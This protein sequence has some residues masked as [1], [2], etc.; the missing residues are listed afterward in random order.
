MKA[1]GILALMLALL[2]GCAAAQESMQLYVHKGA[3][4]EGQVQR[5]LGLLRAEYEADDWTL[6]EDERALRELV[7]S[8]DLPDLAI[9]APGEARP[10]AREGLLVPLQE[11]ISGQHRMQRQVLDQGV[12]G[13]EMFMAPLSAMHRQMAVN[14][15]LFEDMGLGYMLDSKMYPVWYPAQFYQILEEFMIRDEVAL[16]VWRAQADTSAAIEALTQAI[17]GGMLLSE[18]GGRATADDE[19]VQVG[20]Q[21]LADAIDDGMIG[22]C[23]TREDALE[24][25][26]MGETAIFIDWTRRLQ[27]QAKEKGLEIAERPYPAAVGLPVRSFELTGVCAFSSGDA[28]RDTHLADACAMLCD[29]AQDVLG[30]RG[31]WQDGALWPASLDA[32]DLGATLRSLLCQALVGVIEE[33]RDAGEA[34]D[35]VQAAMDALRQA[36]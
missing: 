1:L 2:V 30:S 31:I 34:L 35:R 9:C 28:Q 27:Q 29:N 20:V 24:R 16:D 15:S 6:M 13:D 33:R 8:G 23:E 21:W 12:L 25:F 18:D 36:K 10:W 5:L 19:A 17:Y 26:W 32:D 7:L 4:E 22:Y 3:L 11:K 14:V